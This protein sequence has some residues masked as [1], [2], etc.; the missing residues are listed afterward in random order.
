VS[1][2]EPDDRWV[3]HRRDGWTVERPGQS[4]PVSVHDDFD[5]ARDALEHAPEGEDAAQQ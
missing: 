3:A 1:V 5:E 4:D 2:P